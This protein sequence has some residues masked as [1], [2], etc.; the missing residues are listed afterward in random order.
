[1]TE[2]EQINIQINQSSKIAIDTGITPLKRIALDSKKAIEACMEDVQ[3]Q[4][5]MLKTAK[6][7]SPDPDVN[8]IV[9]NGIKRQ[10]SMM[11]EFMQSLDN[12]KR[13]IYDPSQYSY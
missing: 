12:W 4:M 6:V 13:R 9:H 1:M 5:D 11:G 10:M 2:N 8:D 7:D 3:K